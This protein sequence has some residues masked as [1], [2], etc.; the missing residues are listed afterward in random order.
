MAKQCYSV[1]SHPIETLIAWIKS[2]EIAIPEIQ[3]PFVWDASKVRNLLDSLSRGFPVGYM[4]LWRNPDVKLK[5]G[6]T[7]AGKRILIDG[8]QRMSALMAA[9]LGREVT[10]KE[11]AKV[12]I[13]IAYQPQEKRFEVSNPAIEKD[14][15]WIPDISVA[16]QQGASLLGLVDSYCRK[17]PNVI[18]DKIFESVE[19]LR[20]IINNQVGIVELDPHLDIETVTEIFVRVN[21]EG[22]ELSQADFAMSKIATNEMYGGH[23][24][25]KAIDYF[26]HLAVAPEF[27]ANIKEN[28]KE[29]TGTDYFEKMSWLKSDRDNIYD[30]S[31][32]DM[33]RVIFSHRFKRGK[34]QD[35]VALLSG[36]NFE[37]KQFEQAIAEASFARLREGVLDFINETDFKRFVAIIRSAGFIDSDMIGSQTALDFAYVLYLTLRD[38]EM[39]SAEIERAVCRWFVF[40]ALTGRYSGSPESMIDSDIR[41]ID[42]KGVDGFCNPTIRAELSDA[43]WNEVLPQDMETSSGSSPY[44]QVFKAAHVKAGDKGFLSRDIT[45]DALIRNRHDVHH[46]FPRNYLKKK[47]YTKGMYNQIAN[48]VLTQSEINIQIGD[49]APSKYFS[50]LNEQINGGSLRYGGITDRKELL[51]NLEAHCIPSELLDDARDDYERFIETRRKLM[52]LK[53]KNYFETL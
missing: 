4:I 41:Q 11:Y 53:I 21:S 47:N 45:V 37:T 48:Y 24:L 46:L 14:V 42:S 43:W 33:L 29:F 13:R 51:K 31:Y 30:P 17:N 19:A 6:T 36:R 2:D 44:F 8:Q 18:K 15:L 5:D 7:S 27:F 38:K 3:R 23:H 35:L 39:R 1:Q 28:D 10:T 26:C 34:L 32:V 12:R 25:R 52:A 49:K 22:K 40:S 20:G 9:L 50:Q 16:F